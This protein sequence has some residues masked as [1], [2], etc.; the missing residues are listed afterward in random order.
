M[1]WWVHGLVGGEARRFPLDE[2]DARLG[3]AAGPG[4]ERLIVDG[5]TEALGR[6]GALGLS[7]AGDGPSFD[8]RV[9]D[10]VD[11]ARLTVEGTD[12]TMPCSCHAPD[13]DAVVLVEGDPGTTI[14][15]NLLL[16]PL[17]QLRGALAAGKGPLALGRLDCC[18]IRGATNGIDLE[19]GPLGVCGLAGTPGLVAFTN[20]PRATPP[21]GR[22]HLVDLPGYEAGGRA[23]GLVPL[24]S[25]VLERNNLWIV[26][27]VGGRGD[28]GVLRVVAVGVARRQRD[29]VLGVHVLIAPPEADSLRQASTEQR[30]G[31]HPLPDIEL[32]HTGS[33]LAVAALPNRC[34]CLLVTED[35]YRRRHLLRLDVGDGTPEVREIEVDGVP[36]A[37]LVSADPPPE[38]EPEE[39]A[40]EE[41][42]AAEASEG[43]VAVGP[44]G[45][46]LPLG[47][48]PA[49]A[50][51]RVDVYVVG[52][53]AGAGLGW[54]VS[55]RPG[56]G[57]VDYA[58]HLEAAR[59]LQVRVVVEE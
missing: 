29:F 51:P 36:D 26:D 19:S 4:D 41:A 49:D 42:P 6:A 27:V 15:R 53:G 23:E 32:R 2:E 52:E 3:E 35:P 57:V 30:F 18:R 12:L 37:L 22:L 14:S 21:L 24:V 50:G 59:D 46:R 43:L 20:T 54:W 5:E 25:P 38:P 55:Q 45:C 44:G 7:L 28:D 40:E 47:A 9:T 1:T 56:D 34:G 13:L 10:V 58:L 11:G 33:L 17:E 48:F 39:V 31:E 16:L 8:L